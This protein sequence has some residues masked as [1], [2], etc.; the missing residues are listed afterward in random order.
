[1]SD[2]R[3]LYELSGTELVINDGGFGYTPPSTFSLV[4]KDL[5]DCVAQP[6]TL[7][8]VEDY[9]IPGAPFEMCSHPS[10]LIEQ[11]ADDRS[12]PAASGPRRRTSLA[13]C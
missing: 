13:G 10:V 7:S 4:V 3:I 11:E 6:E 5:K 12:T 2:G 8:A 9:E 1:V